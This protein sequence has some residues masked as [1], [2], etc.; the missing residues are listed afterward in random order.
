MKQ[1]ISDI[2]AMTRQSRSGDGNQKERCLEHW[3]DVDVA[4][5]AIS[6][7]QLCGR[8]FEPALRLAVVRV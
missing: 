7:E 6:L 3:S 4:A 2:S 1:F 8:R 5:D